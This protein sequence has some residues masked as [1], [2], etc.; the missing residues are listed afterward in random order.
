MN[1]NLHSIQPLVRAE[2]IALKNRVYVNRNLRLENITHMGFDMDHT[3]AVY[4]HQIEIL[5]FNLTRDRLVES[6]GYPQDLCATTYEVGS[7]LRGLIIDK[8][9]GNLIKLDQHK[10][11]ED[12]FH[13]TREI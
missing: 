7:V 2:H 8:K 5:A 3:L 13:G 11:V 6:Y 10:Y 12:A 4:N 9:K 1:L